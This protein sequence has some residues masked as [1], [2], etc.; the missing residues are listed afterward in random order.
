MMVQVRL[1][2]PQQLQDQ[3]QMFLVAITGTTVTGIDTAFGITY[4]YSK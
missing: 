3:V 4:W 2:L 1:K